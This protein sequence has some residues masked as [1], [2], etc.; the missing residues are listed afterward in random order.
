[1]KAII[2]YSEIHLKKGNFSFF[3]NK[4]VENIKKSVKR[5]GIE[6]R[7]I[8]RDNKRI[9]FEFDSEDKKK[10]SR[11]IKNVF[12]IRYFAFFEE[13][14]FDQGILEGYCKDLF[15][16]FREKG[17]KEIAFKTKRANKKF[18][19]NTIEINK[20]LG[21][22]ANSAGLKINYKNPEKTIFIEIASKIYLYTERVEGYG[23][24]PVGT[25]GN[26]LCL[27]SGGIDSIVAAWLMMKRGCHV[28]FLHFHAY[29]KNE[30]VIEGKIKTLVDSLNEFQFKSK[31]Y[32]V[33]Y[34]IYLLGV[35][36]KI[37][38]KYD[39]V[40]FKNYLFRFS[41]HMILKNKNE[42]YKGIVSGDSLAQVA[43]QTIEN[44]K[45][46]SFGLRELIFRPLLTYDKEDIIKLAKELNLYEES[47]KKYKDCCSILSKKTSL[48]TR[49]EEIEKEI[50]KIDF[51]A[52]LEES[53]E[54]MKMIKV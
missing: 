49:T 28:D 48:K 52:L 4:L 46:T 29:P 45:V 3:E 36:G 15:S 44:L 43:S 31:I 17:L 22:L 21:E 27:L 38:E 54:E 32:F 1:M 18:P 40:L 10:L 13:L 47:I 8:Y 33:P 20:N 19:L 23:G 34:H 5:K 7:K 37:N 26:V 42:K 41:E 30:E 16:E 51:G 11:A 14:E 6:V 24:L 50:E 12:G 35:Q 39:L 53:L 2:H 25:A 9:I